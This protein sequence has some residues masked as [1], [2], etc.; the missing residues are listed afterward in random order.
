MTGPKRNPPWSREELIL[1]LDLYLSDGLL[2]DRSHKVIELSRVLQ[3][4][5]AV[6]VIDSS[7]FRNPNGVAMKLGNFAALDPNYPGKG[8]S[9][10]GKGDK[11]IWE[12]FSEKEEDLRVAA[13]SLLNQVSNRP[14]DLAELVESL[15][16]PAFDV[17]DQTDQRV[18][19][20]TTIV[21]RQGQGK[22]RERLITAYEGR[23]AFTDFDCLFSLEAAHILGYR[24]L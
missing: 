8:L 19:I 22:F 3:R 2:D 11:L 5:A 9:S 20:A 15:E 14:N 1:A 10:G 18:R 7:V 16:E 24:R 12:E 23:C 21:A 17:R 4:L 6:E 13:L